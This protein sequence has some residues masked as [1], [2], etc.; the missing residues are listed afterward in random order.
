MAFQFPLEA[1]LRFR[2]Q[3][4]EREEAALQKIL[5]EIA[6]VCEDLALLERQLGEAEALRAARAVK[7]LI[8]LDLHAVYG[9]VQ[10]IKQRR[11]ELTAKLDELGQSRDAQIRA[12]D[13]A[14]RNR[15]VLTTMRKQKRSEYELNQSKREQKI[16][17]D[18]YLARR[19]R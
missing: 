19:T 11:L 10:S 17:D 16:L 2:A 13:A 15:E 14:R 7:P 8:G 12:Y 6:A 5:A 18:H 4:E 3:V 1:V 9:H